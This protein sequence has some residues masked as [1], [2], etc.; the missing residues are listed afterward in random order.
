MTPTHLSPF[1]RRFVRHDA[2]SRSRTDVPRNRSCPTALRKSV[3][4]K[5]ALD[6]VPN[7]LKR[8]ERITTLGS[9]LHVFRLLAIRRTD[10]LGNAG[11][12]SLDNVD[13]DI[14]YLEM[15]R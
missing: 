8:Q 14:A 1:C 9:D 11:F 12:N 3:S 13:R 7:T 10:L 2:G 6:S 4:G 5:L 15:S